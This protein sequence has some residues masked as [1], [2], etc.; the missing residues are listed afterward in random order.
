MLTQSCKQTI[1]QSTLQEQEG[2]LY[3][4]SEAFNFLKTDFNVLYIMICFRLFLFHLNV[5]HTVNQ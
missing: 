3:V 5:E 2:F 1:K 4:L